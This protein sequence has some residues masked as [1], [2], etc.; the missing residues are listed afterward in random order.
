MDPQKVAIQGD[1]SRK[2]VVEL[3]R[4]CAGKRVVEFGMGGSTL[5]LAQCAK[6]LDSYES[7]PKWF[8]ITEARIFQMGKP[9]SVRLH[10][11]GPHCP[12]PD[13]IPECDVLFIDGFGPMRAQWISKFFKK[14]KVIA[15]HDARRFQDVN[16]ALSHLVVFFS[17]IE[18]I[19]FNVG[20][21]NLM[22]VYRREVPLEYENWNE[23]EADDN[24]VP[25]EIEDYV[26]NAS[27]LPGGDLKRRVLSASQQE[28]IRGC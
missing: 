3:Y 18:R 13:D 16:K 8:D 24:R 28:D 14:A 23:T 22:V 5:I 6:R 25:W 2:D 17:E 9:A 27:D 15:I 1:L 20:D 26:E 7:D 10:D 12:L 21:S 19:E 4:L 11:V